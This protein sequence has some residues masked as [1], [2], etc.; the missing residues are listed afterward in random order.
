MRKQTKGAVKSKSAHITKNICGAKA[1]ITSQTIP[2]GIIY[3][4]STVYE[5]NN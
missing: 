2:F 5:S 4:S 1:D 3:L